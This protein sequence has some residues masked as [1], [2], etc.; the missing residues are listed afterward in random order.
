MWSPDITGPKLRLSN[1]RP[2]RVV[3]LNGDLVEHD[4]NLIGRIKFLTR[5][6]A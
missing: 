2:F 5:P 3:D 6:E 4:R 1:A